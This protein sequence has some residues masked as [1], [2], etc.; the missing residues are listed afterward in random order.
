M[1][2]ERTKEIALT[3][4]LAA[5]V[6]V[7]TYIV[8]IPNPSTGGYIHLGDCMIFF[9]V[10]MVG[11]KNG[12]LAAGIGAALSDLL[13]GAAM[14]IVPTFFVKFI[15][16]YVMGTVI[17]NDPFNNKRQLIGAALG[18]I[19]QVT[20]YTILSMLFYGKEAGLVS[21]PAELLQSGVGVFLFIVIMKV[22]GKNAKELAK[23]R[24]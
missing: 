4:L 17:N 22:I 6:F 21:I 10:V 18:G 19:L 14:W 13:A 16:A 23:N 7:A 8:R 11:R 20:G 2:N 1:R 15:M 3:A 12:A 5:L 9:A 24:K